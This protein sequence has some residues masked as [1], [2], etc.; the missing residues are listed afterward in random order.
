MTVITPLTGDSLPEEQEQLFARISSNLFT[1]G[2][3]INVNCFPFELAQQLFQHV[4]CLPDQ[5]FVDAAIGRSRDQTK[6]TFVRS[7]KLSWINQDSI[8]STAWLQWAAHL[9]TYLNLHL[10]MGL[11]SFESHY[12]H[13]APDDFYQRHYDAF[14][15]KSGRTLSIIIYLN[16]DWLLSDG[17]ELV[18]YQDNNDKVG[19]KV[20]PSFAT[21]V[22]FLSSVFPHEVLRTHRH[23]YSI[24]GWFSTNTT[25]AARV[26]PPV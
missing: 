23:R 11:F 12:S 17:G 22:V 6:N 19:I 16:K 18:L 1:K 14:K 15:S 3:S 4:T 10:F 20:A 13:Y 9:Q 24:A 2:Y 21:V 5:S 7:Q 8:A 25:T 26:D